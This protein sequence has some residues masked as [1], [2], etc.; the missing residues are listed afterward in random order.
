MITAEEPPPSDS[1]QFSILF[2]LCFVFFGVGEGV[3]ELY[4]DVHCY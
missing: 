3:S 2:V 4:P 1:F